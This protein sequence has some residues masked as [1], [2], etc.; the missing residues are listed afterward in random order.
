[1]TNILVSA[2]KTYNETKRSDLPDSAFLFPDRSYPIVT[3]A[4]VK[5]AIS[6]Y[7][8]GNHGLTFEAFVKKLYAKCKKLGKEF[9]AA[10]PESSLEK[11]GIKKKSV[12][13]QL[14]LGAI[15]TAL[16]DM[17]C[18]VI[19]CG[20][21]K[22]DEDEVEDEEEE[23]SKED[24]DNLARGLYMSIDSMYSMISDMYSRIYKTE[25]RMY[26]LMSQHLQGH[27]PAFKGASQLEKYVK[28][29]MPGDVTVVPQTIYASDGKPSKLV[30]EIPIK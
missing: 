10:I 16:A 19:E 22:E 23:V 4:D 30:L 21:E 9:I 15:N 3:P 29:F 11:A 14:A 25:D 28:M 7:G 8:R 18:V 20:E 26:E 5:D 24:L 12:K 17:S 13:A 2:Q 6:N 1:M 27:A